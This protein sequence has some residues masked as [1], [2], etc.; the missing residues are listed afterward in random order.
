MAKALV[1]VATNGSSA[2][3][4]TVATTVSAT[5][6]GN[7]LIVLAATF[8]ESGHACTGVSD[9][10]NAFTAVS[11]S[12][13]VNTGSLGHISHWYLPVSTA[14]KTTITATFAGGAGTYWKACDVME[15]SGFTLPTV[16]HAPS[17]IVDATQGST[18]VSAPS[19]VTNDAAG[20][21]V[22]TACGINT[23]TEDPKSGN[24]FSALVGG[25]ELGNGGD[26]V[27][28]LNSSASTH[29]AQ[30]LQ[31]GTGDSAT[32]IT[33]SFKETPTGAFK[34]YFT[35]GANQSLGA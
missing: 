28:L 23:V 3:A 11:V 20:V 14:G 6:S 26:T 2:N 5:G 1:Q 10:T 32:I 30:W 13:A 19:A 29:T 31:S 22:S 21:V 33:T 4:N 15:V 7:L 27:L 9:G 16:D 25:N 24:E 17:P 8:G 35:A 18:T 12:A 34:S